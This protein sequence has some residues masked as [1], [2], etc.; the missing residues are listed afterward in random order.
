MTDK[1]SKVSHANTHMYKSYKI[2]N[3]KLQGLLFQMCMFPFPR[4]SFPTWR[5]KNPS[6]VSSG[7]RDCVGVQKLGKI[8]PIQSLIIGQISFHTSNTS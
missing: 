5:N 2:S 1:A 8:L 7:E 3:Y 6:E 4:F